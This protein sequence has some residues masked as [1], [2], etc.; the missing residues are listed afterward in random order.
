MEDREMVPNELRKEAARIGYYVYANVCYEKMALDIR[1][2]LNYENVH[3]DAS[4]GL[5]P[6]E[7]WAVWYL[8]K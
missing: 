8:N 4:I 7:S 2:K 3:Y 1:D 6:D 5:M